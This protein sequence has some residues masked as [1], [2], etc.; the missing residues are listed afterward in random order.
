MKKI[1]LYPQEITRLRSEK[2]AR[3][4]FKT[5]GFKVIKY[6]FGIRDLFTYSV[7]VAQK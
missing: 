5:S 6:Y 7:I 1:T 2:E 3:Q 4:F